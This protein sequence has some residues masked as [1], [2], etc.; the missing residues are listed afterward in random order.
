MSPNC[1][2]IGRPIG[3]AIR[4]SAEYGHDA[5]LNFPKAAAM[6]W[7][8]LL[9]VL[10]SALSQ[11]QMYGRHE[12]C[13]RDRKMLGRTFTSPYSCLLAANRDP[14]CEQY[15][16]VA[17][18]YPRNE[19]YPNGMTSAVIQYSFT[20]NGAYGCSCC[21][22]YYPC[23][24][25]GT[26]GTG[27]YIGGIGSP[28][29]GSNGDSRWN[30]WVLP[31]PRSPPPS[32]PPPP[33]LPP[34]PPLDCATLVDNGGA[35]GD[36]GDGA[37]CRYCCDAFGVCSDDAGAC[38]LLGGVHQPKFSAK[39]L[40]QAQW[41]SADAIEILCPRTPKPP[42]TPP[43][44]PSPVPPPPPGPPGCTCPELGGRRLGERSETTLQE[45]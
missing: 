8:V 28:R 5:S 44:S 25:K 36:Q 35:C 24:S 11:V 21:R 13:S 37:I 14:G 32:P 17:A 43:P 20:I 26:C 38:G 45:W 16:H 10:P 27:S 12:Q 3:G 4:A 39:L 18:I 7:L 30:L 19:P 22:G 33:S 23:V 40:S 29:R 1:L 41:G 9:C 34:P 6:R 31:V 15:T 42:P 2:P